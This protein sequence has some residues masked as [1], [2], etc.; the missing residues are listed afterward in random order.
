MADWSSNSRGGGSGRSHRGQTSVDCGD[1]EEEDVWSAV[2]QRGGSGGGDHTRGSTDPRTIPR[3]NPEAANNVTPHRSA[4]PVDVPDWSKVYGKSNR[5]VNGSGSGSG[6]WAE[7]G[8]RE[9]EEEEE[10]DEDGIVPPHEWIA[11]KL[12]RTQISS[13]SMCEGMG[14]TLK[15]RDLSKVRNAILTKTGFL[16]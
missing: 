15:G 8:V 4:A 12:A 11:R 5:K 14:R 9:A 16:E 2:K 6:S 1:L 7:S 13:S 10:E 3:A